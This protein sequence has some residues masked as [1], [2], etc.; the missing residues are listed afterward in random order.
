[1]ILL[2][3]RPLPPKEE[4]HPTQSERHSNK[5][6][7]SPEEVFQEEISEVVESS[8]WHQIAFCKNPPSSEN[9]PIPVKSDFL[10]K[11]RP[12]ITKAHH[13]TLSSLGDVDS[14]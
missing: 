14:G 1:M 10:N 8:E 5:E 7:E 6:K 11:G 12:F 3:K 13:I 9:E 4:K 2:E